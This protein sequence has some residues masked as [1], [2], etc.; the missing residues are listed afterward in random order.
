[1]ISLLLDMI[2]TEGSDKIGVEKHVIKYR[3][4]TSLFSSF[5]DLSPIH[6][7]TWHHS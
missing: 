4:L 1:M 3:S 5:I 7:G 2:P 6:P